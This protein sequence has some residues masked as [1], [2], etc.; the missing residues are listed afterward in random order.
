MQ[1]VGSCL[2]QQFTCFSFASVEGADVISYALKCFTEE[3]GIIGCDFAEGK[4]RRNQVAGLAAFSLFFFLLLLF[5]LDL[6]HS[7]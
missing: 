3:I 1:E 4:V 6:V 7:I 5:L 2:E